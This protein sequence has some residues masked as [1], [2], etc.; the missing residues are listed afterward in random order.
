MKKVAY[1]EDIETWKAGFQFH[2]PI[3]VRFSE[4]D[5]FGHMNNTT[6]FVYFEEARIEYMKYLEL[7]SVKQAKPDT[8]P[9][10]GDLQCDF[11]RQVFFD[12]ALKVYV[13]A[14]HVGSTS[15]DLHYL[16]VNEKEE[17]CFTGRGRIVHVNPADGRPAPLAENVRERLIASST[18]DI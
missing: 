1:I 10:V 5:M 9:V 3:T 8:I 7:F 16:G 2:V 18:V 12:D 13:K 14:N 11:H 15:Y 6:P 4:T 17:V